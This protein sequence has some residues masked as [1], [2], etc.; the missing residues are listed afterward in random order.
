MTDQQAKVLC[1][2]DDLCLTEILNPSL[3]FNTHRTG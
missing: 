3:G 2:I 1:W